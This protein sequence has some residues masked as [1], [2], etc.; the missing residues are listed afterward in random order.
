MLA[1]PASAAGAPTF[2]ALTATDIPSLTVSKISDFP[3][4]MTPSSHAHGNITNAGAIGTAA[5]KGVYTG[6][7]GVLTAGT[8]PIAAGGTGAT[9]TTAG[10]IVYGSST[11]AYGTTAAGTSGQYLKSNATS[12]PTWASFVT[13]VVT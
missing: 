7:N 11:T 13:P 12:A 5:N 3:S 8:I 2:R 1:A 6:T 10:G 4:S 9:S